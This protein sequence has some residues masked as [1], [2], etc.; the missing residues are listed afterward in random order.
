MRGGFAAVPSL[1]CSLAIT[2]NAQFAGAVE[3]MH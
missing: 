2:F 1:R 3:Q